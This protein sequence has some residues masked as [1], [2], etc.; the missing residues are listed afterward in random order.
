MLYGFGVLPSSFGG[1][2]IFSFPLLFGPCFPSG[3]VCPFFASS[4]HPFSPPFAVEGIALFRPLPFSLHA[5]LMLR[6]LVLCA[7]SL[8]ERCSSMRGGFV[9]RDTASRRCRQPSYC[10]RQT[11][12]VDERSLPPSGYWGYRGWL[13]ALTPS[14]LL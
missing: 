10:C 2:H 8:S 14:P 4:P 12:G 5:G 1:G 6:L 11:E 7:D 3:A 13:G 9:G